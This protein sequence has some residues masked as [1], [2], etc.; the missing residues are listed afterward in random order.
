MTDPPLTDTGVVCFVL[1]CVILS[2]RLHFLLQGFSGLDGAKGDGGPAGPK[3]G[4]GL[5]FD[6]TDSCHSAEKYHSL[7]SGPVRSR[8]TDGTC[9]NNQWQRGGRVEPCDSYLL[10]LCVSV[11]TLTFMNYFPGYK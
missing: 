5:R 6:C 11:D 1:L 8:A 2:E 3:V 7:T 9:S 10:K 4:H